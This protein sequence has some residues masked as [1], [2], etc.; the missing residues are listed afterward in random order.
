[1]SLTIFER[2][3][4]LKTNPSVRTLVQEHHLLRSDFVLPCFVIEGTKI[5]EPIS[6]LPGNYRYSIDELLK[7]TSHWVEMGFCALAL[8]PIIDPSLKNEMGNEAL[9]A[10]SLILRTIKALK[11]HLPDLCLFA[12][13]ALDPYTSHGHDGVLNSHGD[14]DND[15]TIEILAE[16]AL[17]LANAGVDF[18]APSDMMDGRIGF[19]RN[20][21]EKAHFINTGILSYTA[22]FASSLYGPFRD[23]VGSKLKGNKKTY[24]MNP[25][26]K[27][28]ALREA[29]IDQKEGADILLI[30]PALSYLDVIATIKEN[31]YLPIAAYHVSGEYA[32]VMAAGEKNLLDPALVLKEHLLSIKRAGADLIFTYAIAAFGDTLIDE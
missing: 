25:A 22:K 6:V 21:L 18:V 27:R 13:V 15:A 16:M 7:A 32:M 14:V 4:R 9:A 5:K 31:T 12:D 28:E 23:T 19:I 10:N 26:N 2:T 20:A 8:F 1:M 29:L 30:K 11:Q 17:L 24:Q 3:R